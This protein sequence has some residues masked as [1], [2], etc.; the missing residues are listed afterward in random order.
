MKNIFWIRGIPPASLAIV[1]CPPGGRGLRDE[2][3]TMKIR[4]IE[5]LVSLLEPE[6]AHL[7]GLSEE[8]RLAEQLGLH[9]FSYP[10]PDAHL[11]QDRASFRSFVGRLADRLRAGEAVGIHCRGSIGRSAVAAACALIHLGWTP[12]AALAAITTARGLTV[13]DTQEQED[14]ILRYKA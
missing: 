1:L 10:I 6:E 3:L 7:L 9:F 14:W 2:L 5:I 4:G 11:P 12:H 13:P 8:G